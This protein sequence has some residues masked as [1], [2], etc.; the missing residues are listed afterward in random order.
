MICSFCSLLCDSESLNRLSCSQRDNSLVHL[1]A[2]RQNI[3]TT[4][5]LLDN[6]VRQL[7]ASLLIAK[8][9][10]VTGRIAS[11]QTAREAIAFADRFNA[12]LDFSEGGHTFANVLAIQRGGMNSVSIAE[13]RQIADVIVVVGND[14]LLEAFPR[15]PQALYSA[16]RT[17]DT[18]PVIV[19]LGEFNEESIQKWK[20]SPFDV[21]SVPCRLEQVPSAWMQWCRWNT[22]TDSSSDSDSG[23]KL[24]GLLN[25]SKFTAIVWAASRLPVPQPDLWVERML[26]AIRFRN[27]THR[28]SALMLSSLDGTFQQVCTWLTGFPGRIQFRNGSPNYDPWTN[29]YMHWLRYSNQANGPSVVVTLDETGSRT[30]FDLGYSNADL[31]KRNVIPWRLSS[32][33]TDTPIAVAGHEFE[34][35][36]F[37]ADLS[38]AA[39]VLPDM[40]HSHR[41]RNDRLP[42]TAASILRSLRS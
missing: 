16:N 17:R 9:V 31:K 14:S 33:S 23:H 36:V 21:W 1:E 8:R 38:V 32:D 26:E 42:V 5:A 18:K 40:T 29:S 10:L 7:M 34:C 3:T 30:P 2:T 13:V 20:T 25:D 24:L 37:R 27:E 22:S 15:L 19:L 41:V 6:E 35:D 4:Q 12:T 11:I 39:H 28:T